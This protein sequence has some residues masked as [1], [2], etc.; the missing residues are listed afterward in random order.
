MY[1][2][3][4][5][6]R[7]FRGWLG[8]FEH[9][10][11]RVGQI[12]CEAV[13]GDPIAESSPKSFRKYKKSPVVEALCELIFEGSQWDETIVGQFYERVKDKFPIRRPVEMRKA[14]ITLSGDEPTAGILRLPP[15]T[16]FLN[17]T[18]SSL[19]QIRKDLLAV[20]QL[21]P[22]PNFA[23]WEP[24]I[25]SALGSY[26]ELAKPQG[27]KRIGLRYI[28]RIVIPQD[29][30]LP[31]EKYYN[32]YPSIPT[33][34]KDEHGPFM[35]RVQLSCEQKGHSVLVTF[36][37]TSS[38]KPSETEHVLDLYGI[39]QAETPL[40]ESAVRK[41]TRIAHENVNK[42]FEGSIKDDLRMLFEP[43]N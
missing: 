23:V 28:N 18:G 3:A 43:E 7:I 22:Y 17:T 26:W 37:S 36:A 31:M 6:A 25:Y 38:E 1:S 8:P 24:N 2:E 4:R 35:I 15:Q 16:Q 39:F 27:V 20:N 41:E 29:V 5:Q 9:C 12:A 42:V 19:V 13:T 21:R 40:E 32:I 30:P 33:T 14:E 34:W 10:G 11:W